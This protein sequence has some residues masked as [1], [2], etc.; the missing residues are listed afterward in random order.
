MTGGRFAFPPPGDGSLVAAAAAEPSA[1][2]MFEGLPAV[3]MTGGRFVSVIVQLNEVLAD[4]PKV[5]VT[6]TVTLYVPAAA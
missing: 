4:A 1:P 3:V 5:S 6:D 2:L